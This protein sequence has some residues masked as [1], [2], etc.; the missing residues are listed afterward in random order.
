M[1]LPTPSSSLAPTVL[2]DA[3]RAMTSPKYEL[4]SFA[5]GVGAVRVDA[6]AVWMAMRPSVVVVPPDGNVTI[7]AYDHISIL[8]KLSTPHSERRFVR[9]AAHGDLGPPT[10]RGRR[11]PTR[12]CR[13]PKRGIP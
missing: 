7:Y 6:L 12:L 13:L 9:S 3:D 2:H 4:A 10:R 8:R 11:H 1:R 5:G